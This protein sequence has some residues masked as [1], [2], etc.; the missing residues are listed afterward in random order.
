LRDIRFFDN[1]SGYFFIYDMDGNCLLLPTSPSLENTN[2]LDLQDAKG[3]YTIR[4]H[5]RIVKESKEGFHEWYWYKP[6]SK[7]MKK[8]IGF[9]KAYEELGIYIG[10]ARYE[11]D[12]HEGIKKEIQK[13]LIDIRYAD[14]GYI[15]AYDYRGNTISHLNKE[16]I[17]T[18][19][20]DLVVED[21][22]IIKNFIKGAR[23]VEE[24]SFMT[25]LATIDSKTGKKDYKTSFIKDIP[26]LGWVIGTG[27]YYKDVLNEIRIKRISLRDKLSLVVEK[28]GYATLLVLFIMLIVT[29]VVS[30]KLHNVL[31]NYQKNLIVK[32][33]QTIEQKEQLVYQLEHD[34]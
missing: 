13:L 30:I 5:L 27:A 7:L 18:N 9:V 11:E 14:K 6:G 22:H 10:T 2:L 31:K 26:E 34:L 3:T 20:W 29:L 33:K 28:I 21:E 15:F 8:K 17:G 25:Y 16:F 4:E 24:G 32:H 1:K 19:R 23:S 12:I